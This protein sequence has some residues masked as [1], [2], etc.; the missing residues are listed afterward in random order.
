V[1]RETT[2]TL[3]QLQALNDGYREYVYSTTNNWPRFSQIEAHGISIP[4]LLNLANLKSSAAT[5]KF[6]ALDGFYASLTYNQVFRK[7]Y[8]YSK[9][10]EAGSSGAFSVEPVIAWACGDVGRV[11]EENIRSFVGQSGPWEVN[12]FS[13]VR[14]LCK[15]EVSVSSAGAWAVPGAS[16]ATGSTVPTGS[17]FELSHDNIDNV[18]IYYTLDGSEPNYNSP[19]YNPSTSYFQPDLVKPLVLTESVIIKAFAAGLGKDKSTVATFSITVQ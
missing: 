13:S 10:S 7:L 12:T 1:S 16:I 8:S 4:Y 14:D 15:I 2:W 19:V 18:R 11:R 9:H 5:F 17:K 6:I 3:S